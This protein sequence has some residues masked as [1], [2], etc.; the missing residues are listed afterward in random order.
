MNLVLVGQGGHSKVLTDI[1]NRDGTVKVIGYLDDIHK[2]MYIEQDV[3]YAPLSFA[4]VI[5]Q[6]FQEVKWII[7]VGHNEIRKKIV[8]TLQL[9]P[10]D[11]TTL[12]HPSAEISPSATLG[13]GTV[14]M[15]NAV[16]N[17]DSTVGHHAIINSGAIIEHDNRVGDYVHLS[18]HAT[19][20]GNVVI[21]EGVH[22][23]AN[24]TVIPGKTIGE[25]SV[26]GAGSTV[27]HSIPPFITAVGVPAKVKK[28]VGDLIVKYKVK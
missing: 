27:I 19:L 25:W 15:A 5:R 23:G 2:S 24:S 3:F 6:T 22:L 11:Y 14:V 12:I 21:E 18:P 8:E 4:P 28:K 20:T 17:A 16:I 26:I 9:E 13:V 10:E 7:G 1:A